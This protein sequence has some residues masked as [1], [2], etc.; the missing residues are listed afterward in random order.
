MEFG[1]ELS[2]NNPLDMLRL[3]NVEAQESLAIHGAMNEFRERGDVKFMPVNQRV[4]AGWRMIERDGGRYGTVY[5]EYDPETR[6]LPIKGYWIAKD[7]VADILQAY[8]SRN[9]YSNPMVGKLYRNFMGIGNMLNQFQLTSFFHAGFTTAETQVRAGADIIKDIYGVATGNRKMSDLGNS[10]KAFPTAFTKSA[11]IGNKIIAEHAAPT[12]DIPTNVAARDLPADMDHRV[13]I[14]AKA[15]EM[16]GITFGMDARF[17]THWGDKQLKEWYGGQKLKA[18]LRSPTVLAEKVMWPVMEGYVPR[19]KAAVWSGMVERILSMNPE[20]SLADLRPE[21][22]AAG[23]GLEATMG[24]VGYDRLFINNTAKNVVQALMRASGWTGGTLVW[25]GGA[26]V[27]AARFVTDW[28]KTG[29]APRELP[30]KV[31]YTVALLGGMAVVNGLMTYLFTGESPHGMDYWA[32]R[33]GGKDSKGR[34]ERFLM[35]TYAKDVFGWFENPKSLALAKMHPLW[36]MMGEVMR[37]K[38]YYGTLIAD[39]YTSQGQQIL[40]LGKYTLQQFVPFGVR[41][42]M[43]LAKSHSF[44]E[45]PGK[46]IAPQFGIMPAPRAYT[47]TP[48]QQ[49]VEDYNAITRATTTTKETAEKKALKSDLMKLARGGDEAGF[50]E[51]AGEAVSSGK[52][53][54]QQVKGIVDESQAPPGMSRFT[55]LPLE[56]KLRTM[57]KASDYEKQTWTPYFLKSIK[58]EKIENLIA[59]RDN[60]VKT[61]QDL[62]YDQIADAVSTLEMPPE[63]PLGN[64]DLSNLGVQTPT[65]EMEGMA[66]VDATIADA[67]AQSVQKLGQPQKPRKERDYSFLG[68]PK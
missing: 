33:T 20:K 66:M 55:R 13:A 58:N 22:R 6:S 21:L 39:P 27:D 30:D 49:V 47:N 56:W 38:D 59:H 32:F 36:N 57:D 46:F 24:Q 1:L 63:E 65:S 15:A 41:G 61:L 62:G 50:Q 52:I 60:V 5:G 12:L 40:D 23:N 16:A 54:R 34:D 43:Q 29:K 31:A 3:K 67:I 4:P 53:T 44:K 2:S 68:I 28:V 19:A 8:T 7:P 51:M 42:Q 25:V 11:T 14:S 18:I 26:P 9:L 64:L 45:S 37:N 35:P 10:I 48:A 17:R